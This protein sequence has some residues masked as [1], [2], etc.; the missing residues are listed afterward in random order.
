VLD[1]TGQFFWP[2]AITAAVAV[3]GTL[4]WVLIVGPLKPVVWNLAAGP[5]Q[6]P[7]EPA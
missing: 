2:F 1:R 5:G 3:L 6:N 4:A 7:A